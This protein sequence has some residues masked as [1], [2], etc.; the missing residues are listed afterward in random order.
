MAIW[1]YGFI[2]GFQVNS[3]HADDDS[4]KD[5]ETEGSE[6]PLGKLMKRLKAKGAKARK[7]AKSQPA[8]AGVSNE[9]DFDILRMV[10]EINSD[11][12][13]TTSKIGSNNDHEDFDKKRRNIHQLQKRKTLLDESKDVPVPKRRRTSSSQAHKSL[14][15][16]PLK[17]IKV[18]QED[19]SDDSDKVDEDLQTSSEDKTAKEKMAKSGESD[20]L[21]S[22]MGKKFSASSK[23]KGKRPGRDNAETLNHSHDAKVCF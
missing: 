7:E 11:N 16:S 21:L 1:S 6:I 17:A 13:G 18:N 9:N 10:K 22:R 14:Q 2:C 12:L 5:S 4:M 15:A 19:I 23:Q 8:T 3:V 20:L